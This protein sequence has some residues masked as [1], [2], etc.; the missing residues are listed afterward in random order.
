MSTFGNLG[1]RIGHFVCIW[2]MTANVA[3]SSMG[4]SGACGAAVFW[5]VVFCTMVWRCSVATVIVY[6]KNF[7][8]SSFVCCALSC[9]LLVAVVVIDVMVLLILA[10]SFVQYHS[11]ML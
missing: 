1:N 4:V 5:Y 7:F 11:G 2:G 3:C 6:S 9:H 10:Y 8:M